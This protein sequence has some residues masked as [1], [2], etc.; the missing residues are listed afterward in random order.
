M[1]NKNKAKF[2][3][4]LHSVLSYQSSD[5]NSLTAEPDSMQGERERES[6]KE[7]DKSAVPLLL[8]ASVQRW[9]WREEEENQHMHS[10]MR[11]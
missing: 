8:P 7:R 2:V 4:E 1:K 10:A 5:P 6:K 11:S 3:T 9:C